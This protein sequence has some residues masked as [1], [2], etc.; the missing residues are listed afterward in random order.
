MRLNSISSASSG[1]VAS[2]PILAPTP[3]RV[4]GSSLEPWAFRH[5]HEIA[6]GL[7]AGRHRPFDFRR[8]VDV[9]VLVDHDDV[10]DV[11]VA[12]E[13]AHHDVL[14]LALLALG[15]LHMEVIA[16]HAAAREM[17]VAH[18]GKA[19]PQVR[20]QRRLA[21]DA[22]EQ[23]VLEPAA[24]DGVE[25]RVAALR[26][27][28]DLDHMAFGALAVILRELAERPFRL[29]HPAAAGGLPP[30]SRRPPARA[31]RW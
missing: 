4:D 6:V 29:A 17:H 22:A 27:G 2:S 12:G 31:P 14:G 5:D 30:R 1:L 7:E 8:I 19:A 20:E 10:L 15:D 23:E 3:S 24:H 16:A 28:G 25:Q 26:H 18:V 13:R 9:D 21:R 11:V